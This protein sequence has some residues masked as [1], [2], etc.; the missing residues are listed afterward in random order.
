VCQVLAS[1]YTVVMLSIVSELMQ[2][3][4]YL[5]WKQ[6]VFLQTTYSLGTALA[7]MVWIFAPKL[8][9]SAAICRP[10]PSLGNPGAIG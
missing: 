5:D 1:A 10:M 4:V 6:S 9:S 3:Q 7:I 2:P 8:V